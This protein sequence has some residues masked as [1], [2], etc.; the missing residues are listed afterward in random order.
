VLYEIFTGR[1]AFP[2]PTGNEMLEQRRSAPPDP[3]SLAKDLDP[4]VVQLILRCLEP[5]PARRPASA[6]AVATALPGGVPYSAAAAAAQQQADRIAAFR[7]ELGDLRRAGVLDLEESRLAAIRKHHE[8]IL[9]DLVQHFDVDLDERGKHLSLG[10]RVVSLIGALALAA[11]AFFFF[12]RIWGLISLP[13]QLGILVAVPAVALVATAVIDARDRSG[14]FTSIAAFFAFAGLI[15]DVTVASKVLGL[16]SSPLSFLIWGAFATILAYGYK[17]R[18]LLASGIVCFALFLATGIPHAMGSYW[19]EGLE[20]W[21]G[22][23]PAGIL[24]FFLQGIA[25]R[26]ARPEFAPVY[27]LVGLLLAFTPTLLLVNQW[28]PSYLPLDAHAVAIGYQILAFS[29]SAGAVWLGIARR[30]KES[31][32]LGGGCFAILLYM[33]FVHWWWNWMPR[34]L[35]FLVVALMSVGVLL[36]MKRLRAAMTSAEGGA[37]P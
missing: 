31:V 20:R 14:Y 22:F 32:Y 30:W 27:R 37:R 16:S 1:S 21:E 28:Q 25:S 23:I 12:Y 11:S 17:L 4:E 33:K 34:Y 8:G 3:S 5:E 26:R 19:L 24:A 6:R 2:G 9:A 7:A 36:V 29:A 13:A 18:L 10:M 15:L 35:F